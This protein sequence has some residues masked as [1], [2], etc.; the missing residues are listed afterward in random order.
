MKHALILLSILL[1]SISS[2]AHTVVKKEGSSIL[3]DRL[4]ENDSY[5]NPNGLVFF[6]VGDNV[7][8]LDGFS[9]QNIL[10][11]RF[12]SIQTISGAVFENAEDATNYCNSL[13]IETSYNYSLAFG[14]IT[15]VSSVYKFGRN[16]SVGTSEEVIWDGG[17][18]Y[19]F[20][21]S[22]EYMNIKSTNVND[23]YNGDNAWNVII[24]GLD[25]AFN[26]I[27]ETILLNGT[28]N[29]K[30]TKKYLRVFRS[31]VLMAGTTTTTNGNN[32]G[33]I[34]VTSFSSSLVQSKILAGNGQTL[35]CVYTVP[36]GFTA[37]V[38]GY[39]LSSG[40]GK[41]VVFKS[42]FRNC[43]VENC[44][45]TVK[46]IREIYENTVFGDLNTPLVVPEKTDIVITGQCATGDVTASASFGLILRKN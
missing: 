18:A 11:D 46:D 35:M 10:V 23:T 33:D 43:S 41:Q 2:I 16:T 34:T 40:Q 7:R 27:S 3:I 8:Y 14:E 30:S 15:G 25:S 29:V 26:E 32:I 45:F 38:T 36:A 44:A 13:M 28:T 21:D 1:I 4:T 37:Y 39:S 24:F 42:K 31:F 6:Y 20:L 19:V 5:V 22:A 17:S 9:G 12:D